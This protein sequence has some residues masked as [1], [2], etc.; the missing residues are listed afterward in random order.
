MNHDFLKQKSQR[1]GT[2]D[3]QEVL[4]DVLKQES[5]TVQVVR[6]EAPKSFEKLDFS[7]HPP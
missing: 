7:S 6:E 3:T 1:G 4:A 5:I 2:H